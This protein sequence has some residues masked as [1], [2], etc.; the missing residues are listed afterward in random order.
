MENMKRNICII[1]NN[2]NGAPITDG[3]RIKLRLYQTILNENGY[4]VSMIDLYGWTKHIFSIIHK[5]KK[6]IKENDSIIIMAGPKGC[7]F[8]IPL[9]NHY[10]KK[11]QKKIIFSA[12]G[13]GT[14]DSLL[15]KMSP[16]KAKDFLLG[17]TG[18]IK[19]EKMSKHLKKLTYVLVEN[20]T[21][22][23]CYKNFYH[24]NNVYI[25]NNFRN[26]EIQPREYPKWENMQIIFFSRIIENKGVLD[27]MKAVYELVNK[28]HL[29]ITLNLYG[30]MQLTSEGK[31]EFDSYLINSSIIYHGQIS[32]DQGVITIKNNH[33]FCLPTKYHGEG[34]SGALV[35]S[36]IAGTPAL[37]SSYSQAKDLIHNQED[38]IIFELNNY[39]DL[40]N[41]IRFCYEN[42]ELLKK[43]SHNVQVTAKKFVFSTYKDEFFDF[44]T[45]VK[46][47]EDS[48]CDC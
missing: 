33:L 27:L 24:L 13:V 43:I 29:N 36:M 22:L 45:G 11:Y 1:G 8:I 6:A 20:E 7:R 46:K 42:Y 9:V 28:E 30:E 2:A 14:L 31:K 34:T 37:V 32:P 35:E 23:K 15:A 16:E 38:G 40:V 47:D 18:S 21:L 17:N 26:I 41:K 25:L 48:H 39:D 4:H 12:L 19:D 10:N 5:I 44:M 3:G